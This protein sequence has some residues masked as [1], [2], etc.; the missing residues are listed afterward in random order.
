M[1]EKKGNVTIIDI[2]EKANVTNITVS[3]AFNKPELVKPETRERILAIAREMN[4][5]PNAF[6]RTLKG[7]QSNIIGLVTDSTFNP[8]YSEITK[9]LCREAAA[10]GYS[11]MMFETDGSEEAEARAISVLF[12]Y[13]ASGILLSPVRDSQNY[14]PAYLEQAEAFN[15]PIVLIDRDIPN[16]NLPGVFLDNYEIGMK[17]SQYLANF[18]EKSILII[19]GPSDSEITQDRIA[20]LRKLLKKKNVDIQTIYSEYDYEKALPKIRDAFQSLDFTPERIIGVNG[21]ISLAAIKVARETNLNNVQFFS[22]DEV[23][24]SD[25]FGFHVPCIV[26]DPRAW[27]KNV[28][29]MIFGLVDGK[30]VEHRLFVHGN[31]KE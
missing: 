27:G 30:E 14:T 21:L 6:A 3:R 1:S 13:K 25:I 12:S 15:I 2:A 23:P 10:K 16:K 7:S 28:S 24:N 18:N 19:G 4:Y 5:S 17:A 20:G 8:V 26:N 31:L 29:E 22:I 11:V 9:T